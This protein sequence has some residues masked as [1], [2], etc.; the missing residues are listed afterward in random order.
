MASTTAAIGSAS[1]ATPNMGAIAFAGSIGTIIEWYDFLIY[2]TA[3]AL[4]FNTLFFP[5][6]DPLAGTLASLATY[7]VGFVARPIGGAMFGYF[8][9]RI[10]RK[11]DADAHHGRH[12]PGHVRDRPVC[13]PTADR[14]LGA[15]PAGHPC[16]SSRASGWAANGAAPSLMVLEHAPT[17]RRGFFGSLVQ[18]GFPLGLVTSSGVFASGRPCCPKTSSWPGAGASPSCSASC[19]W[20]SARSSAPA[21][22][23]RRCSR[24][25]SAEAG[26]L[27]QSLRR[28]GVQEPARFL[29][30][31]GLKL[32]EV[33]WVY[34]LTVFVVV[35]AT[36]KL[37]CRAPCCS[38]RSSG[39]P[40]SRCHHP[41]V[42]LPV[43]QDRPPAV[44]FR[45]ARSSPSPSPSRCSGSWTRRRRWIVMTRWSWP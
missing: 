9:D 21:C 29:V 35:Y 37:A 19:W 12:G 10:G 28:G 8:G 13:R 18:V 34:M 43:G 15:G 27:Q 2:G 31:V 45:S 1:P 17:D 22:P 44:L 16:A 23:K 30:A 26:S 20:R 39:P 38:T 32:S 25:S 36:T 24:R 40:W 14:H 7:S 11:I 33:S 41:A 3:A 42:R 5:T 6:I 4:V